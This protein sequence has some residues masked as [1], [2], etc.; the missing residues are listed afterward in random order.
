MRVGAA[1]TEARK[2]GWTG[3]D[4][5]QHLLERLPLREA[6]HVRIQRLVVV[7]LREHVLRTHKKPSSDAGRNPL[8]RRALKR[9][10]RR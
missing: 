2:R 10:V 5:Q 1:Q 8:R 6:A 7:A 9:A 4:A 3:L